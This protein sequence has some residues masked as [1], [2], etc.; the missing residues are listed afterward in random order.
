MDIN[1]ILRANAFEAWFMTRKYCLDIL[2]GKITLPY[3]KYFI[4]SLH[5]SV[6]LFIKQIMLNNNDYRVIKMKNI[7][8]NGEPIKGFLNSTNLNNYFKGLS[9]DDLRK[10]YSIEFNQIIDINR[11]I[12]E[13]YFMDNENENITSELKLLNRLRNE[14]THFFIELDTFLSESEFMTLHGFAIK[15]YNIL[16]YYNIVPDSWDIYYGEPIERFTYRGALKDSLFIKD[17]A[18]TFNGYEYDTPSVDAFG[19]A[20]FICQKDEFDEID[21]NYQ[22]RRDIDVLQTYIESLLEYDMLKVISTANG[23]FEFKFY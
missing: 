11:S 9:K 5:N 12:L 2:D 21:D 20:L 8:K 10:F 18:E 1:H 22:I 23:K 19:I 13:S 6:E 7:D 15:F 16:K 17:L 3:R 14:E 4:D